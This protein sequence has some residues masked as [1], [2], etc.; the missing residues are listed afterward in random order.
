MASAPYLDAVQ[1]AFMQGADSKLFKSSEVIGW[2]GLGVSQIEFSGK[3][4]DTC[5]KFA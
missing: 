5:V 4:Y 3:C 2:G 1:Q